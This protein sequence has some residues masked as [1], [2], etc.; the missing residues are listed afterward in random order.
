MLRKTHCS[1]AAHAVQ[2]PKVTLAARRRGCENVWMMN[3]QDS[4][5][6]ADSSRSGASCVAV[7]ERRLGFSRRVLY[8]INVTL[9]GYFKPQ[10]MTPR[11]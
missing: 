7:P 5:L 4:P 3:R 11:P 8:R 10:R 9:C 1:E 6:E 2:N